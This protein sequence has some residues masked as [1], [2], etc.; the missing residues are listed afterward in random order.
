MISSGDGG[1]LIRMSD[2]DMDEHY[3]DLLVA[4]MGPSSKQTQGYVSR[5]SFGTAKPDA[6]GILSGKKFIILRCLKAPGDLEDVVTRFRHGFKPDFIHEFQHYLL[7]QRRSEK[8]RTSG[9]AL[10]KDGVAAYFNDNDETNA[11]YQEA[12]HDIA[13]FFQIVREKAPQKIAE[14]DDMS[15]PRLMEWCKKQF[16]HADFLA[17]ASPKTTRALNKRLYRFL[18]Q[19]IR[20]MFASVLK[21][22]R[23]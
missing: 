5:A 16:F 15:T 3:P 10:E 7:S 20:P 18:E 12:V 14:F 23:E 22:Y 13:E 11:Y 2:V 8:V 21:N 1:Y 9:E 19:A 17:H 4:L 6:G